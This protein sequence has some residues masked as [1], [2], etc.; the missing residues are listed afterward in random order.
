MWMKI[1]VIIYYYLNVHTLTLLHVYIESSTVVSP[2]Q[3]INK[4]VLQTNLL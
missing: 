1:Y 3:N 2:T 4:C